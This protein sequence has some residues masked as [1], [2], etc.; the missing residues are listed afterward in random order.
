M[1][2][3][4][5]IKNLITIG[6][7]STV[8]FLAT[9]LA[10]LLSSIVIPGLSSIFVPAIAALLSGTVYILLCHRVQMFGGITTMGVM[11]SLFFIVSGHFILAFIP[12]M[13]FALL[14]D[15]IASKGDYISRKLNVISFTAFSFGLIGPILPLWF[16]P[17]MYE[18]SLIERGKDADYINRLFAPIN[19]T[20]FVL[21]MGVT[22]ICGIAGAI[23]GY[24]L[25]DKHF[26]KLNE[27]HVHQAS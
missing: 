18:A 15:W 24:H 26:S 3:T 4:I 13:L 8:Y 12:S 19:S 5:K 22:L 27:R 16:I 2:K 7:Y 23:I 21:S 9:G 17:G 1:K 25:Y 14:A 6:V 11:M 20:T 10:Q